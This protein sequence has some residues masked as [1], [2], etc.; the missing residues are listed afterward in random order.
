[1]AT[2]PLLILSACGAHAPS[3]PTSTGTPKPDAWRSATVAGEGTFA[4]Q[5]DGSLWFFGI[6]PDRAAPK[7]VGGSY[8]WAVVAAGAYANAA[9]RRDGTLWTWGINNHHELGLGDTTSR[10]TPT[11]VGHESD[12]ASVACGN[13]RVLAPGYSLAIKRDGSLWG[14]GVNDSGQLGLGDTDERKSPSR[15]GTGSDWASVSCGWGQTMAIKRNGTLWGWGDGLMGQLGLGEAG[16][17]TP[18]QVESASDCTQVSC[19]DG[20]SLALKK[21]GSVWAAGTN[22]S[23][24]LGIPGASAAFHFVRVGTD[25]DWAAVSTGGE[26]VLALK[27]DGSLWAWGSNG[28]GELGLGDMRDRNAP[29]LQRSG[30]LW[31]QVSCGGYSAGIQRDGSLW[32]WAAEMTVPTR[33]K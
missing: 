9:I 33:I 1:M 25:S 2:V 19:G 32:T 15:V 23:G 17:D 24:V 27:R 26:S 13:Q 16:P 6:H 28:L 7:L 12:W 30:R 18:T 20:F 3:I 5:S 29:T 10:S 8:R 11:Q 14:W 31:V 4:I 22:N 21:D